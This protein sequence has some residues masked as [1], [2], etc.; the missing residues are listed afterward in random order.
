VVDTV[1]NFEALTPTA[2]LDRSAAV[3]ADRTAVVDGDLRLTYAEFHDRCLRQAGLLHDLGVR[4][5]DRVAVL[6]PNTHLMLEAH[7]GVLYAGAV[8]V[9]LNT[10]LS[11]AELAYIVEHSGARVMLHDPGLGSEAGEITAGLGVRLVDGGEEYERLL[12]AAGHRRVPVSDERALMALNYTSGTTGRPKGVMYHHRGAYL[13]AMAMAMHFKLDSESTYLWTLPMFHCSGWCFTW[14]VTLAGGTH[15]CLPQLDVEKVWGLIAAGEV[16]HFCAAPTVLVML[17]DHAAARP[18]GDVVVAVG[19]APPSPTL[20]ERCGELGLQVTHLYGLT[21]TF[22]PVV[23]CDWRPEWD[24]LPVAEQAVVRARQGVGNVISC[25]VRVVDP[26]GEDVPMDGATI[27]EVA[28][29]GNNVML[30]YYRDEEAT[31]TAVPD[32]WF[33]TGDLGVLHPDGYLQI[34]D[35]AKDVIISGGE[36]IS[37][38]EVEAALSSHPAVLEAAVIAVPDEKWGERPAAWVTLKDGGEVGAEELRE[39][40]RGRL[41]RFKV[42]D[43]IEFGPLPKTGS[44][45]IRKFELRSAAWAGHERLGP[46]G[47]GSDGD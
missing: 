11:A 2:Y 24:R 21:E 35:R 7:Y 38:V 29:R 43:R 26:Q 36:N 22:G 31:A 40:V 15:V 5:G 39:H 41:A 27:G 9:A 47:G 34:R 16:T 28:L 14:A 46:V 19:G 10:R 12:E 44:G 8:L 18:G 20:L 1:A 6:A 32:G 37:S 33:R 30:G 23:I 17:A 45:K 42:P 3:F 13:Q 4:P 25:A